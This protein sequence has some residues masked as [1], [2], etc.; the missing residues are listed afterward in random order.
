MAVLRHYSKRLVCKFFPDLFF[1]TWSHRKGTAWGLLCI[2]LSLTD[3][4]FQGIVMLIKCDFSKSLFLPHKDS[5]QKCPTHIHRFNI[6]NQYTLKFRYKFG[7]RVVRA[8]LMNFDI[9]WPQEKVSKS[10]SAAANLSL[11][12]I[13]SKFAKNKFGSQ[14][15]LVCFQTPSKVQT[16]R[17][18]WKS[19]NCIWQLLVWRFLI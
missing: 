11:L 14:E 10:P 6:R 9:Y 19:N 3:Q 2:N 5:G 18:L 13:R 4:S 8:E 7:F 16:Q 1:I 17:V 15:R 12:K